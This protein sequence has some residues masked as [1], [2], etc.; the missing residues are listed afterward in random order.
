[1]MRPVRTMVLATCSRIRMVMMFSKRKMRRS[2]ISRISTMARPEWM[3][4][5][6]K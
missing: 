6:T 5:A 2:G 1:M 3:A 4:P